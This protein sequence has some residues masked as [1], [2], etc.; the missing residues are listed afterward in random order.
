M[1]KIQ[2]DREMA[3]Q[4]IEE[5][6]DQVKQLL[7]AQRRLAQQPED[8]VMFPEKKYITA[9]GHNLDAHRTQCGLTVEQLAEKIGHH[10]NTVLDHINKRVFPR[11]L[12]R[13]KYAD[14]F[15]R[16]LKRPIRA[17]DLADKDSREF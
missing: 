13:K 16:E 11:A 12:T 8:S 10:K 3:T 1:S 7:K 15:S 9:F 14:F 2:L 17:L 4:N 6:A 5:M